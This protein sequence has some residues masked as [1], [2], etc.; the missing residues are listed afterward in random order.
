LQ[1]KVISKKLSGAKKQVDNITKQTILEK[2]Y[3]TSND[4]QFIES[5]Y[6]EWTS[7][8]LDSFLAELLKI[9]EAEIKVLS[10]RKP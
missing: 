3:L 6:R 2:V 7:L 4:F 5:E 8:D 9:S 10:E 1:Q